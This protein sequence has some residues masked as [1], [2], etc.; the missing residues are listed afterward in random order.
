MDELYIERL[1]KKLKIEDSLYYFNNLCKLINIINNDIIVVERKNDKQVIEIDLNKKYLE[2]SLNKRSR[3]KIEMDYDINNNEL[4]YHGYII[5]IVPD[6]QSVGF[7][8][9]KDDNNYNWIDEEFC[10]MSE[11]VDYIDNRK[12][13]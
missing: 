6:G 1:D 7:I 3:N 5:D 12:D 10:Y 9:C 2:I 11:A 13:K 4:L 8:V